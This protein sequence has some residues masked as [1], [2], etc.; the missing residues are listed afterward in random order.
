MLGASRTVTDQSRQGK[1]RV[2]TTTTTQALDPQALTAGGNLV[3][4]AGHDVNL[5]AARLDAGQ[6]LAVVA[7]NDLNATTLTT[8]DSRDTLETRKRFKQTT[9]VS[10][11]TVHGTEFSAGGDIALQAGRDLALTAASVASETGGIALAAGR[12]VSLLAAQEQHDAEQDMEKKKKGFLSSKTT[13]THDEWHD[14]VAVTTSLSG[15]RVSIAAGNDLR[16]QGAQIV[17]TGD[18]VLAA[19]NDLV[20]AT[21]LNTSSEDHDKQTRKSGMFGSGGLGVTFGKQKVDTEAEITQTTHTGST[22]GSLEGDVTLVA[23]NRYQQTG[24]DVL[25]L[26]GDI[27]VQAKD[28]AITEAQETSSYDQQTRF[29]Q[30]GLSVS[31]SSS[32][33]SLAQAANDTYKASKQVDGDARMQAM[34]AGAVALN[35][36]NNVDALSS[37]ASGLASGT[38]KGAA[39]GANVNI[40]I[41]V[42]GSRSQSDTHQAGTQAAGSTVQAGG[43]VSLIATGGG[44]QSNLL[45]RGSTITAGHDLLVAAD[46]D[47]ILEAARNTSTQASSNKSSSGSIGVGI[48]Y[49]PDGAA[50][51][52]MLS[53][54]SA[55]GTGNGQDVAYTE[56]QLAAGGTATVVSGNDTSLRGAQLSADKVVAAIG[57]DLSIESLQ[58]THTYASKDKSAGG[59]VTIGAGFSASGSY[60]SNKVNGDYASIVEQSGIQAG[61]GGFDLD[62]AGNTDLKGGVIASTRQAVDEGRN[63]LSTGTLTYSDLANASRYD[64]QGV[65]LSGG[66]SKGAGGE[67]GTDGSPSTVNNGSTWSWQNF[68]TGTTG[69]AAGYVSKS[70]ESNATT[71]SGISG[72]TLVI[73]DEAGQLAKTGQSASEALAGLKREVATGDAA[74]GL[75]QQWDAQKL[76]SQVAAGAQITAA[77]GQQASKAVGDYAQQKTDEAA[78]L[79]A[80]AEAASD[81]GKKADL[82]AQAEQLESQWG[83]GGSLRLLA[84]TVIGGLTGG[85]EG[86]AGA[87]TGTLTA[88]KVAEALREAGVTGPL[89]DSL[90]ALASGAVGAAAGGAN[91]AAA[92]GNEVANNWLSHR[93]IAEADLERA[94]CDQGGGDVQACKDAVTRRMDALD[95]AREKQW[96]A[97]KE[98]VEQEVSAEYTQ[99]AQWTQD[100]YTEQIASRRD[101]YWLGTGLTEDQVVFSGY[102]PAGEMGYLFRSTGSSVVRTASNSAATAIDLVTRPGL[103]V[104]WDMGEA[105]GQ[106]FKDGATA[107]TNYATAPLPAAYLQSGIEQSLTMTTEERSDAM[108]GIAFGIAAGAALERALPGGAATGEKGD[109]ATRIFVTDDAASANAQ[110]ALRAKLSGLQKA[111]ETAATI[112]TLPDGRF[113][114][115]SREVPAS[116]KGATRGASFVTEFDPKTGATRQWMESYDHSGSVIR[117]HPKSINGQ[118]VDAQH[119]PPTG[120]EL[121]SWGQE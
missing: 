67:T 4:S 69:G 53:A 95:V 49:G 43:D 110:A 28:I 73:T 42:G 84:H 19:G 58:D 24:S 90:T 116:S 38:A 121:K 108:V 37:T 22:V 93:E 72:G 1:T 45:V 101:T 33:L 97:Y 40:S 71:A 107:L 47:V 111:Q 119:Y 109:A 78:L 2:V 11:E 6:G 91:G 41:S 60:S 70:G 76:Q 98:T 34:A 46:H 48:S 89:A 64:A 9:A 3:L 59:S 100:E 81:P 13:T 52:L 80:Q 115:Y 82:T 118:P 102:A 26:A 50:Y 20:L 57:G 32:A 10:D 77:F 5:V 106:V 51:G 68:Q 66:Y 36:Y 85:L 86:A 17:G 31:L 44:D 54:S 21:A 56:S 75:T 87:A 25:A 18:V 96:I 103:A 7:G 105:L 65:N 16:S 114:Y 14:S 88:P 120:A 8:V 63:R 99:G 74:G 39:Q 113:R 12:D 61:N 79:R 62:V 27:A 112:K 104:A 83:D 23:G 94:A 92:A 117:V 15:E 35:A 30:G 29:K 55:K